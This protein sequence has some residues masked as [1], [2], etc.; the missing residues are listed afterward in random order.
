MR[1]QFML[2]PAAIVASAPV[3]ADQYLSLE[4]AQELLFPGAS[5]KKAF[6]SINDQQKEK[7]IDEAKVT[8][9]SRHIKVWEVSTGGWF[10]IDQVAGR[11]DWITYAVALDEDGVVKGIEILECLERWNQVRHADWRAQFVGK[12]R[13]TLSLEGDILNISGTTLSV[14]HI[15]EGVRRVL[16][17]HGLFVTPSAG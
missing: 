2:I 9:W 11:D 3:Q 1:F 5:F 16:V 7:I 8:V 13:G 4:K 17:T 14:S 10:F 12:R 6:F 15:T